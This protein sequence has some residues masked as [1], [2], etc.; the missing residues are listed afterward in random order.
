M[1]SMFRGYYSPSQTELAELWDSGQII[2]DTNALLNLFRYSQSAREDFIKALHFKRESLWI[3]HQVGIEFHR[4]RIEVINDQVNAFGAIESSLS[5]AKNAAENALNGYKRHPSLDT[6]PLTKAL[7]E[8]INGLMLQL[9]EA[10]ENHST[11]VVKNKTNEKTLQNITELYEGRVGSPFNDERTLEIHAE[12]AIRFENEIPP[13]Y[14]DRNKSEPARY[15]DLVL[16]EQILENSRAEKKAA[17]FVTDDQKEDWWYIVG[18][19]THGPRPELVDDYFSACG[20]RI[21]FLTPNRFL[22]F[23]KTQMKGIRSS[24]VDEVEEVSRV[25]YVADIANERALLARANSSSVHTVKQNTP[26]GPESTTKW[27]QFHRSA[28]ADRPDEYT[29]HRAR[30]QRWIYGEILRLTEL[31]FDTLTLSDR[32]RLD[33]LQHHAA[34]LEYSLE[35]EYL[36]YDQTETHS[37]R[38]VP[39]Y[40]ESSRESLRPQFPIDDVPLWRRAHWKETSDSPL[41]PATRSN[42]DGA[43]WRD[44]SPVENAKGASPST[45]GAVRRSK[46]ATRQI[47]SPDHPI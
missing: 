25:R 22:D 5:K 14:K 37:K 1:R 12:G 33:K 43:V 2:L 10:R 21:H 32:Q 30:E 9:Q 36:S 13:G 31:P 17:I 16:W 6:A 23:A 41:N 29:N 4:R 47:T 38:D 27:A 28:Y 18:S 44:E 11:K 40:K 15:G 45:S 7:Q 42:S 3:P 34:A 24:S 26:G 8:S 19:E 20:Q 46:R 39:E 35:N